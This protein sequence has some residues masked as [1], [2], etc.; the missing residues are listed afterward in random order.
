[1]GV[2]LCRQVVFHCRQVVVN[3]SDS[4]KRLSRLTLFVSKSDPKEH[5]VRVRLSGEDFSDLKFVSEQLQIGLS[6]CLRMMALEALR[7]KKNDLFRDAAQRKR[8]QDM[9]RQQLEDV[10]DGN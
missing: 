2:A 1:M 5:T 8:H 4:F 7:S 10:D 6:T 3:R 9:L